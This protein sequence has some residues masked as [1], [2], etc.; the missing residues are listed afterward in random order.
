MQH[1]S[2]HTQGPPLFVSTRSTQSFATRT[3]FL[4]VVAFVAVQKAGEI[5]LNRGAKAAARYARHSRKQTHHKSQITNRKSQITNRKSQITNHKSRITHSREWT[6]SAEDT[7]HLKKEFA[8]LDTDKNGML[9]KA[10]AV[11]LLDGQP[12]CCFR[13]VSLCFVVFRFVSFCFVLFRF[14][15]FCFVLFRFVLF[16]FVSF[17]FVLVYVLTYF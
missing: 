14:V 17:R 8:K 13:F 11:K 7:L 9:S 15:S 6:L 4:Q 2:V 1:Y 5:I 12:C 3:R 10:E 16:R